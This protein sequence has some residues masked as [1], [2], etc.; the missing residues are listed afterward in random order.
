MYHISVNLAFGRGEKN[1]CG[2]KKLQGWQKGY[3][4]AAKNS[5][6]L[7]LIYF[8]SLDTQVFVGVAKKTAGGRQMV[9]LRHWKG[10]TVV[11]SLHLKNPLPTIRVFF[12]SKAILRVSCKILKNGWKIRNLWGSVMQISRT[13]IWLII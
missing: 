13:E 1:I 6:D 4:G 9:T 5:V 12:H 2:Y 10:G 7:S 3:K 8:Y 11:S